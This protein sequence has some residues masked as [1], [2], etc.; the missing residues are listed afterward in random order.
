M[1]KYYSAAS[2]VQT[3]V[4]FLSLFLIQ[5]CPD[6]VIPPEEEN[7]DRI[8]FLRSPREFSEICTMKPDGTDIQVLAHYDYDGGY[9]HHG[10]GPI[11]WSPDKSLIVVQGGPRESMEYDPLWIMNSQGDLLYRLTWNGWSPVWSP[12][13]EKIV[14]SRRR[15]PISLIFNLFIIDVSGDNE[16]VF[17]N[18]ENQKH[19]AFDWSKDSNY[20]LISGQLN[21]SD[22]PE[23]FRLGRK[24]I[25]LLNVQSKEI[26]Y[27]TNNDVHDTPGRYNPV[28]NNIISFVSGS[29]QNADAYT[30]DIDSTEIINITNDPGSYYDPVWSPTGERIAISMPTPDLLGSDIYI[31]D[32]DDLQF[33]QLTFTAD[34]SVNCIAFDW[35]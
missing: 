28:D 29:Y 16:E 26:H 6:S 17:L 1:M 27:L 8:L 19:L 24:E 18:T 2:L 23:Y 35:R 13:G 34:D 3:A 11:R 7:E 5:G 31:W 25:G 22:S 4:L 9:L 15:S 10:Y 14:Y 20:L 30:M 32:L 21:I 12:D 33:V